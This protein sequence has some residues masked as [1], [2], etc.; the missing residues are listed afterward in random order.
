MLAKLTQFSHVIIWII[1]LIC[2]IAISFIPA[3]VGIPLMIIGVVTALIWIAKYPAFYT[4]IALVPAA[5]VI[6]N[7]NN[8]ELF[9]SLPIIGTW[10][11][12]VGDMI[13]FAL[14]F[15]FGW[16]ALK[17]EKKARITHHIQNHFPAIGWYG[18]FLLIAALTIFKSPRPLQYESFNY[19][20]RFVLLSYLAYVVLPFWMIRTKKQL[21][22]VLQILI[23]S[24]LVVA[25]TSVVTLFTSEP[26]WGIWRRIAPISLNGFTPFGHNHNQLSEFLLLV[27]PF[28]WLFAALKNKHTHYY[29]WATVLCIVVSIFTFGRT[30]WI[31]MGVQALTA[32]WVLKPKTSAQS[33]IKAWPLWI[34]IAG[35]MSY[36]AFFSA[37][38]Y[39][40]TSTQSRLD[41]TK[42]TLLQASKT[43]W[44]GNGIGTFL[45]TIG[46]SSAFISQYGDP[47]EAHGL[48]Q[49]LL[50]ETGLLGLA[51]FLVFFAWLFIMLTHKI[52]HATTSD[53]KYLLTASLV[54]VLGAF[55]FQL[56]N[57]SYFN[58][59]LW[60]PVGLALVI[61]WGKWRITS[62]LT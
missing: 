28:A 54:C 56:F 36:M 2:A 19:F 30:A 12:P 40:A 6:I 26:F 29:M 46:Q 14:L 16:S 5:G 27:L 9:R 7:L 33:I 61:M 1:L 8:H 20:L 3:E 62:K 32:W 44:L 22:T 34:V 58:A 57:T 48:I 25:L 60:L 24:S 31:V 45:P 17:K 41:L 55:V 38:S 13:A 11:A 51:S 15:V 23:G 43:P 18:I 39:V 42:F 37:S 4:V 35:L 49:K 10:N 59:K 21:H 50:F 53:Y 52:T 47:I